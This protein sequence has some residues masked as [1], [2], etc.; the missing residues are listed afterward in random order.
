M[1]YQFFSE[2]EINNA[3][4]LEGQPLPGIPTSSGAEALGFKPETAGEAFTYKAELVNTYL[5]KGHLNYTDVYHAQQEA[6]LKGFKSDV[7]LGV[8]PEIEHSEAGSLIKEANLLSDYNNNGHLSPNAVFHAD[9]AA[10]LKSPLEDYKFSQFAN[11]QLGPGGEFIKEA[12][13]IQDYLDNETWSSSDIHSAEIH[14]L[15]DG[16]MIDYLF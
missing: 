16:P 1:S 10:L 7:A 4:Q 14:G 5:E 6:I 2:E 8:G 3:T 9:Q 13:L 11:H 12:D 15:T